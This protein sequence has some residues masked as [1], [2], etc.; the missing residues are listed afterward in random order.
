VNRLVLISAKTYAGAALADLQGQA[1]TAALA[2]DLTA[3]SLPSQ[4]SGRKLQNLFFVVAGGYPLSFSAT[5]E[6]TSPVQSASVTFAESAAISN[7][8][9]VLDKL[10]KTPTSPLNVLTDVAFEQ[11]ITLRIDKSKNPS[12]EFA[13]VEDVILGVDYSAKLS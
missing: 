7:A 1:Q 9:P 13:E 10:S 12:V 2:F 6:A 4:E 8:P 5:V 3:L 11:T